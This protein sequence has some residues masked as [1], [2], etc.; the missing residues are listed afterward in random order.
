LVASD[1]TSTPEPAPNELMRLLAAFLADEPVAVLEVAL[2]DV[3]VVDVVAVTIEFASIFDVS[4]DQAI[5]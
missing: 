3:D 2:E 1:V 4:D 5:T